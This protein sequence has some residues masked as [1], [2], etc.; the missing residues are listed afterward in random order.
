MTFGDDETLM[1]EFVM[2]MMMVM[3]MKMEILLPIHDLPSLF[4]FSEPII[5]EMCEKRKR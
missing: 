5:R 3:V 1:M 4:S 2:T